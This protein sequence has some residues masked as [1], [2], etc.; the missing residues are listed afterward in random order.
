MRRRDRTR[1]PRD[2]D[3]IIAAASRVVA[4]M[5]EPSLMTRIV[6]ELSTVARID[7]PVAAGL[8]IDALVKII[9]T[10]SDVNGSRTISETRAWV[11]A[12]TRARAEEDPRVAD[13]GELDEFTRGPWASSD[14][15]FL[16]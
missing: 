8:A 1:V 4:S 9:T 16:P 7:G 11:D 3:E 12:I 14:N 6:H 13:E 15:A 2:V 10:A 5:D